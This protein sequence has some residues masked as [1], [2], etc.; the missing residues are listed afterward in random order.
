MNTNVI[1]ALK[2]LINMIDKKETNMSEIEKIEPGFVA[3]ESGQFITAE[4]LKQMIPKGCATAVTEDILKIINNMENDT[5]LPQEYMEEKLMSNMHL[6]KG[7]QGVGIEKLIN[8]LK[9]CNLKQNMTNEKAW[10]IVFPKKYN[11]L[12]TAGKQVDNHVSMYNKSDLVVEIDKAMLLSACIQYMPENRRAMERLV[13]LME[14][15]GANEGEKAGPM[16]QYNAAKTIIEMTTMPEDMNINLKV[17]MDEESK[18]IQ[19]SLFE[20]LKRTADIQ[21]AKL[22]SGASITDIQRLGVKAEK[23]IDAEVE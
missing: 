18:S 20:Q 12:V 9:F 2:Y 10:S 16:V 6:L 13:E 14:G 22:Q 19:E 7:R 23:I 8:A 15:K 3:P 5:G 21:M 17:G 11:E 1:I 4:R